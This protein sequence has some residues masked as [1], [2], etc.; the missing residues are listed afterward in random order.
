MLNMITIEPIDGFVI[1]QTVAYFT[2]T[3]SNK[4]IINQNDFNYKRYI[5]IF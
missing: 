4:T 3:N 1:G 2:A 5:K